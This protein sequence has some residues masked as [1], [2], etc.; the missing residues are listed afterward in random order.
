M[1]LKNIILV[2]FC[3]AF[4]SD[5]LSAQDSVYSANIRTPQLFISG[6]QLGYPVLHLNG[7]DQL[8]LEFDDLDADVKNYSFT[9]ELYNAD[10]TPALLSEFDYLKGFSQI[11]ITEYN[12][13]SVALTKY[14]H[15]RAK[16][17]DRNAIPTRSGNYVLKV[18]LNGDVSQLA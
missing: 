12:L 13:S 6:N 15:Y 18:F 8:E 3:T 14:T 2:I 11:N 16:L 10:W 5:N 17:P 1:N 4:I 9:F 7:T